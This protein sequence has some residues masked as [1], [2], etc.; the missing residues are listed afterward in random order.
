VTGTVLLA[1]IGYMSLDHTSLPAPFYVAI[2][3]NG[4]AMPVVQ[5]SARGACWNLLR[6][7]AGFSIGKLKNAG[8]RVEPW[9]QDPAREA[10]RKP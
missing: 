2:R 4:V 10:G 3:P 1:K 8:W 5:A 6:T 9:P 7:Q